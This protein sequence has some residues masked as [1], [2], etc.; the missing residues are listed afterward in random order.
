M[1]S[2]SFYEKGDLEKYILNDISKQDI[3][4]MVD[5]LYQLLLDQNLSFVAK[6]IIGNIVGVSLNFD[7]WNDIRLDTNS[8][9]AVIWEF[10]D[11]LEIPIRYSAT[12]IHY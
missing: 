2:T 10:E 5:D 11:F 3:E 6:D 4:T 7:G 1:V 8:K 12:L 9:L